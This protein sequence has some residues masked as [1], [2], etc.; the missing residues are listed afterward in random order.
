MRAAIEEVFGAQQPVQ[1]CRNHKVRN[2][3]DE[4]PKEQQGEALNLTR[5]AWKVKTAE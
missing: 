5:A 1:C 4:L 2:V 3:L